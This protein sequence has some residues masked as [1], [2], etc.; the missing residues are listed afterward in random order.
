MGDSKRG[1]Q[2]TIQGTADIF[3]LEDDKRLSLTKSIV[4]VY[5]FFA[6]PILDR[7]GTIYG[8]TTVDTRGAAGG[9][10]GTA[11]IYICCNCCL[12]TPQRQPLVI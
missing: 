4:E 5:K 8:G 3:N 6:L 10:T 11:T 9:N 7:T 2:G 1:L 12:S